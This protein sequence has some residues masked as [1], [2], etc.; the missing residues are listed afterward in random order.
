M[1]YKV[2]ISSAFSKQKTQKEQKKIN[3]SQ[4]TNLNY[5]T[6]KLGIRK[7]IINFATK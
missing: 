7:I 3:F 1:E 6:L 5:P 2:T 4:F